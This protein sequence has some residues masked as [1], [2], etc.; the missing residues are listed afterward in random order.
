VNPPDRFKNHHSHVQ[1]DQK[2]HE[3][4]EDFRRAISIRCFFND[5]K[6]GLF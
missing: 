4:V 5:V 3:V 1:D 2:N 6:N